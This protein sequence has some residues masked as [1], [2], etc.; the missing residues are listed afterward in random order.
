MGALAWYVIHSKPRKEGQVSAYLDAQGLETFYPT[1]RVQPVN[2]RAARMRS[3]FPGYLFVRADLEAVGV[4]ALQWVPGAIRLVQFGGEPARVPDNV[5]AELKRHVRR[6]NAGGGLT[7]HGLKPGDVVRITHGPLAGYEAV[8][9]LRLSGSER[10]QVLLEM[11]GRQVRV[12]VDAGAIE[13]RR[14]G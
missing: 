11:L 3:Y 14:A 5:I 10:V 7:L 13:K 8:F 2:P 12:R 6:V 9:D 4:S 1:V